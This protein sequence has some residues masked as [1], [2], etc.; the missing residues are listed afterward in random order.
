[1]FLRNATLFTTWSAKQKFQLGEYTCGFT[2]NISKLDA[3]F[4]PAIPI[5]YAIFQVCVSAHFIAYLSATLC[6]GEKMHRR[7]S[8]INK[9]TEARLGSHSGADEL[10]KNLVWL[11]HRKPVMSF[12]N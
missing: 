10:K 2:F 7:E 5:L 8:I 9:N 1:M 3:A 12:S 6:Y 11:D 4:V